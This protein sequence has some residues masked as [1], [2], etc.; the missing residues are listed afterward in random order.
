MSLVIIV[1]FLSNKGFFNKFMEQIG[2]SS[3]PLTKFQFSTKKFVGSGAFNK[4]INDMLGI[5]KN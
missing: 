3:E 5:G 2:A 1:L 4:E